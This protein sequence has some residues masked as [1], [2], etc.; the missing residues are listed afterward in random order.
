MF[1]FLKDLDR[2]MTIMYRKKYL[3]LLLIFIFLIGI[4]GCD[5][6]QT[7]VE[8]YEVLT[9]VEGEGEIIK[10]P[11]DV[12]FSSGSK[13]DLVAS[14][15]DGW[16][17]SHW[18][19]GGEIVSENLTESFNIVVNNDINIT[20]IFKPLDQL[21]KLNIEGEGRI[22]EKV[23]LD[24][25][26][27]EPE[28]R[29]PVELEAVPEENWIFVGWLGVEESKK[30]NNP[31]ILNRHE[32]LDVK[33]IFVNSDYSLSLEI[34]GEG[35]VKV[36][37]VQVSQ[38]IKD[39]YSELADISRT[40]TGTGEQEILLLEGSV[41]QI[42][43]IAEEDWKFNNWTGDISGSENPSQIEITG[44]ID[45]GAVF[46]EFPYYNLT[47]GIDGEGKVEISIINV[48]FESNASYPVYPEGSEL[49]IEAVSESGW[50]FVEW[51][52]SIDNID[53]TQNPVQ[54]TL[55][56]D[57]D[58]T[59]VLEQTQYSVEINTQGNGVVE[60]RVIELPEGYQSEA[61]LYPP[62]SIV[63][64]SAIP[65]ESWEFSHWEG[66][67][68]ETNKDNNPLELEIQ[69]N[70]TLNVIFVESESEVNYYSL[71]LSTEGEGQVNED[72]ISGNLENDKY[73][74][75]SEV[76]LEAIPAQGWEFSNW[77]GDISSDIASQ[78][79]IQITIEN[80]YIVTANFSEIITDGEVSISGGLSITHN[81]P[82]SKTFVKTAGSGTLETIDVRETF[83]EQS[84]DYKEGEIVVGFSR[85]VVSSQQQEVLNRL[86][87]DI[88]AH[89]P[90]LNSYLVKIQQGNVQEAIE[91]MLSESGVRFAEP[92]YIYQAFSTDVNDEYFGLQWH[93]PQI[94]LPQAWDSST[95][96]S[97]VR[98]AVLDTGI[99]SQHPDLQNNLNL[100]DGYNFPNQST[101]TNDQF[102]HGTHVA[103]TI[104]ADTNNN[105]GV[106]GIMWEAEI[107]PVKVLDDDG[108]GSNWDIAQ[109]ILYAAG[110][111]DSPKI[112][113]PVDIINMSL[114]GSTDSESIREA[115]TE[116][117]NAG[118][119]I[120]AAAGNSNTTT[121][122][123]PASYPEVISVGS[124]ELNYSNSPI[125]A[126]YS[127][128][129]DTLDVMA[130][131]GNTRVDT[132]GDEYADGVL[133]TTFNGSG[134]DKTHTYIYYQG[135]SMA[136]PH[137]AGLTGLMIAN[138]IPKTQIREILRETSFDLGDEDFDIEFGYG[139]VNAYWAV[140]EVNSIRILVGSRET[141]TI[142]SVKEIS[143][144]LRDTSYVI[145]N[146]PAGT[147]T[148][149]AW[150]D[151][152]GNNQIDAGD[153]LGESEVQTFESGS[154]QIDLNLEEIE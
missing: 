98:I 137:V 87:L 66:S 148:I 103:G 77:S 58:L 24:N 60:E 120:V 132:D 151:V 128:Y 68:T 28:D 146:I 19:M 42:T 143:V 29:L 105:Q 85:V 53:E 76:G 2:E 92:N 41:I 124:V 9:N 123:Y 27:A 129:G 4:W 52:G 144:N 107:I 78:N 25:L 108:Y 127:C 100:E 49:E 63:E 125:R 97:A 153:Y 122:M 104:A 40:I 121:P 48:P 59:A 111:T 23:S 109:G 22:N 47:T 94:R 110:L 139:L 154:Y 16:G 38:K 10:T 14:P 84:Q 96:S 79:P 83:I 15:A 3:I 131:G 147:H 145:D 12:E 126:P 88:Q 71:S 141:D 149:Y 54:I 17:F 75:G 56:E 152:T 133:S 134:D 57:M 150:I 102:G 142:N 113:Q 72:L 18:K 62:G 30:D 119:I 93:Y 6:E 21:L 1:L 135:T 32:G 7:T 89:Q 130:P 101:D 8:N 45:L 116:A 140:N 118:V 50:N 20:A 67:V 13:V 51:T 61:A 70:I 55:I 43:A 36:E 80:D 73:S 5:S 82:F 115:V 95:G 46:E 31:I 91:R 106:A 86:G 69:S 112:S 99:D 35:Q 44:N 34:S 39:D 26:S 74:S 64:F 90:M 65:D 11:Y 37:E 117:A 81:W 138:G 114:G 136:S 33:A